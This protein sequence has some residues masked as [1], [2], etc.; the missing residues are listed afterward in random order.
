M[1]LLIR[2]G[3]SIGVNY[4]REITICS[5]MNTWVKRAF[6]FSCFFPYLK[7]IPFLN[8]DVQPYALICSVAL[9]IAWFP[10]H[11]NIALLLPFT[12]ALLAFLII[13]FNGFNLV[14]IRN[15]FG[16]ISLF[17]VTYATYKLLS[18]EKK[19]PHR[20]ITI[21]VYT[22]LLVGI[23]QHVF[24]DFLSFILPRVSTG[25]GRGVVSLAPEP[26]FYG[27]SC[28]FFMLIV[29]MSE[30]PKKKL[31]SNILIF[32][33]IFLARSSTVVLL[34][35]ILFTIKL[36]VNINYKRLLNLFSIL[37]V[38]YFALSFIDLRAYNIRI[39]QLL[40]LVKNEGLFRIIAIDASI[41]DRVAHIFFS[42]KGFFDNSFIPNGYGVWA[43]YLD[44]ETIAY[45]DLFVA[46]WVSRGDK[47][48]S[49]YGAALFELGIFG[50]ILPVSI[51]IIL[52]RAYNRDWRSRLTLILFIN[53]ILLT[54]IPIS[55]PPIGFLMGIAVY[56]NKLNSE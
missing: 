22:W 5:N 7:V 46:E 54:A 32:Q 21:A 20:F 30:H 1:N 37:V 24:P 9:I 13:F 53:I 8:T 55:F 52:Y 50:L 14:G 17:T 36:V 11:I 25:Y 26:T 51:T 47:I 48:L 41:N 35:L 33:A 56:R 15:S 18:I 23:V 42:I 2:P 12:I 16:Y 49:T 40:D 19:F 31:L 44:K 3:L 39:F 6:V 4:F 28:L 10:K 27:I 45:R 34:L 43:D 29:Q 38:T